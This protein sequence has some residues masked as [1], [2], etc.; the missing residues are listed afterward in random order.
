MLANFEAKGS[1]AAFQ[2]QTRFVQ[3][4][5]ASFSSAILWRARYGTAS[6]Q[7][8]ELHNFCELSCTCR[9]GLPQ[10]LA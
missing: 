7:R 10:N 1:Y 9:E 8:I 2:L 5:S 3:S 6:A 4:H